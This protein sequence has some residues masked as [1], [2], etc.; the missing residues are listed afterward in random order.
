MR[1]DWETEKY[2]E[3]IRHLPMEEMRKRGGTVGLDE[4][5]FFLLSGG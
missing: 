2:R 1:Q 3:D 4:G 5:M